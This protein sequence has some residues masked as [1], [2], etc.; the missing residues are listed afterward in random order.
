VLGVSDTRTSGGLALP[1]DLGAIGFTGCTLY[2]SDD[3][4]IGA[5]VTSSAGVA[6]ITIPVPNTG[7][8]N[9]LNFYAQSFVVD[10][11][12]NGVSFTKAGKGLIGN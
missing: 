1:F 2:A 5:F 9:G 11:K 3:F 12:T 10:I 8:L 4:I 7:P 6:S